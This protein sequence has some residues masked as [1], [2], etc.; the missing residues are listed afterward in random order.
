MSNENRNY[1]CNKKLYAEICAWKQK[2]YES[3]ERVLPN[4]YIG[5]SII[6]IAKG[7]IKFWK[8]SN[9]S[10]DWKEEMVLDAIENTCKYLHKF[11]ETRF[12]NPH[13]WI[14]HGCMNVFI[15]RIKKERKQTAI[16]Y[17]FFVNNVYDSRDEEMC[18]I[19]DETFIQDIHD[20]MT[21]YETSLKTVPKEKISEGATIDFLL[22]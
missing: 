17:S 22:Q 14:T 15:Q 12:D 10:R 11:D 18:S 19:A 9:Y 21:T 20:K 7:A 4:D 16:K 3:D 5:E 2:C 13:A 8:F 6:L 1:V